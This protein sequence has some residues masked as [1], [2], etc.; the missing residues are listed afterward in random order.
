MWR[1]EVGELTPSQ[2]KLARL[3]R[4]H[5]AYRKLRDRME[6]WVMAGR[7]NGRIPTAQGKR[8]VTIRRCVRS[9]RYLLDR[10]NFVGGCKPLLDALC[11]QGLLVDDREECLE[12]VYE[13]VVESAAGAGR[14]TVTLEDV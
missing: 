4:H 11:R 3:Y 9:R 7:L 12:D 1:I 8:R 5:S 14:V 6:G 10:G 2:N 13:Q